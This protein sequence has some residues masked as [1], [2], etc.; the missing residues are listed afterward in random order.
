MA[1]GHSHDQPIAPPR[2]AGR[3]R[4]I[5]TFVTVPIALL[6]A[7]G[8]GLLWPADS[9]VG[10][11][12][13]Y[14]TGSTQA[15]VEVVDTDGVGCS[16][17][18]P[19]DPTPGAGQQMCVR[20]TEGI[21][22]G[23]TVPMLVPAQFLEAVDEG[24]T[25]QAIRHEQQDSGTVQ[26]VFVDVERQT[27][28]FWLLALYLVLVLIV[29]RWRGLGAILGLGA[30]VGTLVLWVIP[31]LMAGQPPMLVTLVGVSAMLFFSVYLAHGIS[32]RTTTALLGTFGGVALAIV[33]ATWQVQA[34]HLSTTGEESDSMIGT[35][36]PGVSLQALLVCGIVI[37]GLGALN[38]VTITQASAVW[39]LHATN[40]AMS[41]T[42]LFRRAMRI[43]S[44]HIA[45]TVYTLA[46]AY[47][48]TALT[49]LV[50]LMTLDRSPLETLLSSEITAEIVRTVVASI[51][52]I[53][54]IPVTTLLAT[55]LVAPKNDGDVPERRADRRMPSAFD[56]EF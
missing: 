32:I 34:T 15:V 39:E 55:V 42:A 54:A 35:I 2:R 13:Y 50:V 4:R 25:L 47:A 28:M 51:G 37:A 48:G 41:R 52:L 6:T 33:L 14:A 26:F 38:D 8:I 29:A 5:L 53:A 40:P 21:D 20:V 1:A 49:T 24:T 17:Q 10:S 46:F 31:A 18:A 36:L 23:E 30:S 3:I 11:R 44:D 7:L 45:S 56:D 9:P 19:A 43:G 16:E 12:T 22:A 27:P